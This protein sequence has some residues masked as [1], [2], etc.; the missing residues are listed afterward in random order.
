MSLAPRGLVSIGIPCHNHGAYL[1]ECL[2]SLLAQ[3]RPDWEAIVVDDASAESEVIEHIIAGLADPR[4]Q[5]LRHEQRKGASGARN[6]AFRAARGELLLPLDADDRLDP[7]YLER[8]AAP[9]EGDP[10]LEAT[11]CDAQV[12]G[13]ATWLRKSRVPSIDQILVGQ[14]LNGPGTLMR[15]SLWERVGPYD[16]SPFLISG[17][18]D[19]D[20]YIRMFSRGARVLHLPEPLYHYRATGAGTNMGA[21]KSALA[22]AAYLYSKHRALYEGKPARRVI[23]AKA[24]CHE[25]WAELRDRRWARAVLLV[26]RGLLWHPSTVLAFVGP[27]L[28]ERLR[29]LGRAR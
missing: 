16:E 7:S 24:C 11:F 14:P 13:K 26:L 19:W 6:T 22:T 8:L 17:R 25:G 1:E 20:L 5:L 12:F 2:R 21:R 10:L 18:E 23:F 4:I 28:R 15:R 29:R 9:L 27:P 3:T